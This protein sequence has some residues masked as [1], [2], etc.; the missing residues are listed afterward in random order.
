MS[1]IEDLLDNLQ[2]KKDS[3]KIMEQDAKEDA[4]MQKKE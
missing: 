3:P 1:Q 2:N 4:Q